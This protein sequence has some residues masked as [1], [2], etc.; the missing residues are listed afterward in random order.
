MAPKVVEEKFK[1]KVDEDI[2]INV[3]CNIEAPSSLSLPAKSGDSSKLGAKKKMHKKAARQRMNQ[4]LYSAS[5][6]VTSTD[7]E[8]GNVF[9]CDKKQVTADLTT[10]EQ[11]QVS[12]Q[13]Q[14]DQLRH[15]GEM[16]VSNVDR[17]PHIS[18]ECDE[19]SDAIDNELL[20]RQEKQ[21]NSLV[22]ER[23]TL[24]SH[25]KTP[26]SNNSQT[27]G[28]C[29]VRD[30][31]T[32]EESERLPLV[33]KFENIESVEKNQ[34]EIKSCVSENDDAIHQQNLPLHTE[35]ESQNKPF[36]EEFDV[37]EFEAEKPTSS[38]PYFSTYD[39]VDLSF[40]EQSSKK[41]DIID[42]DVALDIVCDEQLDDYCS[43]TLSDRNDGPTL[44][45]NAADR[46]TIESHT[47]EASKDAIATLR[48]IQDDKEDIKFDEKSIITSDKSDDEICII[49][50]DVEEM[51]EESENKKR[52]SIL[53]L[54]D[55][56]GSEEV[57]EEP[58]ELKA[59]DIKEYQLMPKE[60]DDFSGSNFSEDLGKPED[61]PQKF[62]DSDS[63]CASDLD[64]VAFKEK[65][66]DE[67][68]TSYNDS[69]YP[70]KI[71]SEVDHKIMETAEDEV[72]PQI[73]S[74][75]VVVDDPK[76]ESQIVDEY[77]TTSEEWNESSAV[78]K[79]TGNAAI[80][81][82]IK[83]SESQINCSSDATD[84]TTFEIE[85]M[86]DSF[87]IEGHDESDTSVH[88][89]VIE[90][91]QML[92]NVFLEDR[93]DFELVAADRSDSLHAREDE[94][95]FPVEGQ[96]TNIHLDCETLTHKVPI[97]EDLRLAEE[98]EE[99]CNIVLSQYPTDEKINSSQDNEIV[100]KH[101]V[102]TNEDVQLASLRTNLF[103]EKSAKSTSS[104][105]DVINVVGDADATIENVDTD[106]SESIEEDSVIFVPKLEELSSQTAKEDDDLLSP[107]DMSFE[108]EAVKKVS[109]HFE[110]LEEL[111]E[112]SEDISIDPPIVDKFAHVESDEKSK[113]GKHFKPANDETESKDESVQEGCEKNEEVLTQEIKME[114]IT[115]LSEP[116]L[117][118]QI[119]PIS[120][121]E[122]SPS[123]DVDV[124]PPDNKSYEE[125]LS[126]QIESPIY[127]HE[128][129][130]PQE[131]NLESGMKIPH[132]VVLDATDKVV[133]PTFEENPPKNNSEKENIPL[134]SLKDERGKDG[135]NQN[136]V[137]KEE[138]NEKVGEKS[139]DTLSPDKLFTIEVMED[140][141]TKSSKTSKVKIEEKS[142][143]S[144][145]EVALSEK[146]VSDPTKRVSEDNIKLTSYASK[147]DL[148]KKSL[149]TTESVEELIVPTSSSL[150]D[151]K[152]SASLSE[153]TCEKTDLDNELSKLV[154]AET[155]VPEESKPTGLS[156]DVT[157]KDDSKSTELYQEVPED[158]KE[159]FEKV[160][161]E[162]SFQEQ[163][164]ILLTRRHDLPN[165]A[166]F[167][168]FSPEWFA[169]NLANVSI[170]SP[171]EGFT[172]VNVPSQLSEEI[173]SKRNVTEEVSTSI[174]TL[175]TS[176]TP[177]SNFPKDNTS[178]EPF[179]DH[180]DTIEIP[181]ETTVEMSGQKTDIIQ[182]QVES[183]S[184]LDS[185][186]SDQERVVVPQKPSELPF[187]S[188]TMNF[189]HL[190][191][192]ASDGIEK[193][194]SFQA[195]TPEFTDERSSDVHISD[196]ISCQDIKSSDDITAT[197]G[198][199]KS[200]ATLNADPVSETA[201]ETT[202]RTE[203][204]LSKVKSS[205]ALL[206]GISDT[207]AMTKNLPKAEEPPNEP[208]H[209]EKYKKSENVIH[210]EN[211]DRI[212][213]E[214]VLPIDVEMGENTEPPISG[215]SLKA[216]QEKQETD[217]DL[218]DLSKTSERE[219][220]AKDGKL[221]SVEMSSVP[222]V[223]DEISEKVRRPTK[224]SPAD[225]NSESKL[226]SFEPQ[227]K[228]DNSD[229]AAFK[230]EETLDSGFFED[231]KDCKSTK[232]VSK[233]V[234]EEHSSECVEEPKVVSQRPPP[235]LRNA[236][237]PPSAT[238]LSKFLAFRDCFCFF[239]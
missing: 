78:V 47:L 193:Y 104:E 46:T 140:P 77:M 132:D 135:K 186:E 182:K 235:D 65:S 205:S 85:S 88:D 180:K 7:S 58:S 195:K 184:R 21:K 166:S 211:V 161:D 218:L 118:C 79:P 26:S 45:V 236:N 14:Q 224:G 139:L 223:N 149:D 80:L 87:E 63:G 24:E 22:E 148:P 164:S 157:I 187:E 119:D 75:E 144:I 151:S 101:S 170:E 214:D 138:T 25:E 160:C 163:E 86:E 107:T 171:A 12:A 39:D 30:S 207:S 108:S 126:L 37:E 5:T 123:V 72:T 191:E 10:E 102:E 175:P 192:K 113:A 106:E 165:D 13:L 141:E 114:E 208:P 64:M 2:Q 38:S 189:E 89:D 84:V 203:A 228:A 116:E 92:D 150:I 179:K 41:F 90:I 17:L 28:S 215:K 96:T 18:R 133:Q 181:R 124:K 216:N 29:E 230:Q 54:K 155:K 168:E 34:T 68:I 94:R 31:N 146:S 73:D 202:A 3:S 127:S 234:E 120:Y 172:I 226:S 52:N 178:Q 48:N 8:I 185:L 82:E 197:K 4:K 55:K 213:T 109:T 176:N 159:V 95:Q 147:S 83:T 167:D 129:I 145:K 219:K 177:L 221:S 136:Q 239:C 232:M 152:A 62:L 60:T 201:K 190:T 9:Y 32:K 227:I 81:N 134:Q 130:F 153:I 50:S 66:N 125:T 42:P 142:L 103:D 98:K 71:V 210:L 115:S 61:E 53:H 188:S 173:K 229:S 143:E 99:R 199:E 194:D 100:M 11:Q 27:T 233:E 156:T 20:L 122:K 111:D 70:E 15:G 57:I 74:G 117:D 56:K 105:I 225:F 212:Y 43:T 196:E 222:K 44:D 158:I 40:N 59:D 128:E 93:L 217:I 174:Q 67:E 198:L 19:V 238:A 1:E 69:L 112:L 220:M 237:I 110:F 162:G 231:S 209:D 183:P 33:E 206:I 97:G 200:I 91:K 36:E 16:E 154:Q 23:V 35:P 6:L 51:L 131:S 137:E 204:N 76:I 169:S 49:R 121:Q